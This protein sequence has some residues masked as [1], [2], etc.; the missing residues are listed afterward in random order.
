M[1]VQHKTTSDEQ[2]VISIGSSS[3]ALTVHFTADAYSECG[4][5]E[6]IILYCIP[7]YPLCMRIMSVWD[8]SRKEKVFYSLLALTVESLLGRG[9]I[10]PHV[11]RRS[12]LR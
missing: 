9:S 8:R 10:H 12:S 2:W 6:R 1:I 7:L 11:A 3:T 4:G 5:D